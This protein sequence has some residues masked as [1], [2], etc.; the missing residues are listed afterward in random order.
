MNHD[1]EATMLVA[2]LSRTAEFHDSHTS[3]FSHSGWSKS[4]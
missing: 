2:A 1:S 4:D 3:V